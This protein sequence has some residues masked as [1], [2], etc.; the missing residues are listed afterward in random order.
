MIKRINRKLITKSFSAYAST[1][2]KPIFY[3]YRVISK[4][5][6]VPYTIYLANFIQNLLK[7]ITKY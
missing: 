5:I 6:V 7:I 3:L 2:L 1:Y 4:Q